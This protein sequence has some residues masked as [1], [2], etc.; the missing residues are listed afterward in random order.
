[1]LD[2]GQ[3]FSTLVVT[4]LVMVAAAA[5]LFYGLATGQR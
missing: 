4:V 1:M 5:L 3:P 2:F